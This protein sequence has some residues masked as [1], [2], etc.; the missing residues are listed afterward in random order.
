MAGRLRDCQTGPPSDSGP[1]ITASDCLTAAPRQQLGFANVGRTNCMC[2]ETALLEAAGGLADRLVDPVKR[3]GAWRVMVRKYQIEI[4]G[5]A[6]QVSNEQVDSCAA[7]ERE[8]VVNEDEARPEL[9]GARC[10]G[11]SDSSFEHQQT[12][13]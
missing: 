7:L 12:L 13:G 2:L 6:R 1:T 11:K 9:A 3:L 8:C 4:D 5:Q 10:R